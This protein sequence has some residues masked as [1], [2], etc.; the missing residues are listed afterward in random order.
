MLS[1]LYYDLH[2]KRVG[3]SMYVYVLTWESQESEAVKQAFIN[4]KRHSG[5][6]KGCLN[7]SS[8]NEFWLLHVYFLG[9]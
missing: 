1:G 7:R 9:H 2:M 4:E 6:I 5:N 8:L 3:D